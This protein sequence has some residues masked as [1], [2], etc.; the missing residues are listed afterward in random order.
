MEGSFEY[1]E[2]VAVEKRQGVILQFGGW[3]W[4]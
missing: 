1:I 2:Y 4:G 3:M